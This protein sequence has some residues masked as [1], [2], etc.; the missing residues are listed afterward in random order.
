MLNYNIDNY[1]VARLSLLCYIS[2]MESFVIITDSG[3]SLSTDWQKKYDLTVMPLA[4]V[5]N[6][7]QFSG[8]NVTDADTIELYA[9]I[10]NKTVISTSSINED[11]VRTT[12]GKILA[13]GKDILYIGFSSALSIS[14]ETGA[15]VLDELQVQYPKRKILHIDTKAA[16]MIR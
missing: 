6:G 1:F 8:A 9:K 5:I 16:G 14:Y 10:K 2:N 12:C 3:A 13:D 4:Y 15:R 11:D 7:E